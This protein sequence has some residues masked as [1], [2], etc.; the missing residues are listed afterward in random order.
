MCD[1]NL[2][3]APCVPV[4]CK[5]ML[6]PD[7]IQ[8][9]DPSVMGCMSGPVLDFGDKPFGDA[10]AGI[11]WDGRHLW[12]LDANEGRICAIEKTESGKELSAALAAKPRGTRDDHEDATG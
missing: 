3:L 6:A 1:G 4:I 12:V 2:W 9:D 10:S 5:T 8:W 11:A 7:P